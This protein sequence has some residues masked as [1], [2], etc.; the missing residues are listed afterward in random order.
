[1]CEKL[2]L[3]VAWF[4]LSPVIASGQLRPDDARP[5]DARLAPAFDKMVSKR[6]S[7]LIPAQV[8]SLPR[9]IADVDEILEMT[10][11]LQ[12]AEG[13]TSTGKKY[14]LLIEG[15]ERLKQKIGQIPFLVERREFSLAAD[16]IDDIALN[17]QV[18]NG[19]QDV[20]LRDWAKSYREKAGTLEKPLQPLDKKLSREW[21]SGELKSARANLAQLLDRKREIFGNTH[22]EVMGTLVALWEIHFESGLVRESTSFLTEAAK[23]SSEVYGEN[24]WQTVTLRENLKFTEQLADSEPRVQ[25]RIFQ[26]WTNSLISSEVSAEN[27]ENVLALADREI[28]F[29]EKTLGFESSLVA[30]SYVRFARLAEKFGKLNYA[31]A[32]YLRGASTAQKAFGDLHPLS[33]SAVQG[34]ERDVPADERQ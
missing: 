14:G 17:N 1:M 25:T 34:L 33:C 16:T 31:V 28:T 3:V 26:L 22:T 30:E 7:L 12:I 13:D 23:I 8:E 21:L 2:S 9:S 18:W 10:R 4:F 15:F 19:R 5:A 24:H 6:D 20:A 27:I 11:Q 29:A 32:F